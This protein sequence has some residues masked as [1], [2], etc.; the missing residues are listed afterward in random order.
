MKT[1]RFLGIVLT[2][3]AMIA[4]I[5]LI[6]TPA[7]AMTQAVTIP[8]QDAT[9][10]AAV[11]TITPA[12]MIAGPTANA[13][14]VQIQVTPAVETTSTSA[15]EEQFP[16]T[17]AANADVGTTIDVTIQDAAMAFTAATPTL[18]TINVTDSVALVSAVPAPTQ[19]SEEY[20]AAAATPVAN[21][22]LNGSNFADTTGSKSASAT[23]LM[24]GSSTRTASGS[25]VIR[26]NVDAPAFYA[27][28]PAPSGQKGA[29][30]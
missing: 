29:F 3:A 4:V 30:A 21:F 10:I 14:Q 13:K 11:S 23:N 1:R 27:T 17:P 25:S 5:S 8:A 9:A 16:M 7:M 28:M 6:T 24:A 26:G 19:N 15:N 20:M 12:P 22:S 18:A 2:I